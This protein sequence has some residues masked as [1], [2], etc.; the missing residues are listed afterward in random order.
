VLQAIR[1]EAGVLIDRLDDFLADAA[2]H[3]L[4]DRDQR[5]LE[6][7]TLFLGRHVDGGLA[8]LLHGLQRALVLDLGDLVG[9]TRRLLHRIFQLPRT[10]AGKPSQNFLFTITA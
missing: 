3:L 8:T 6:S 9:V 2:F 7:Q 5:L 1:L 10:S 4:M